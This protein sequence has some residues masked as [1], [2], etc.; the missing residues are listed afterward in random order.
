MFTTSKN[1]EID[2]NSVLNRYFILFVLLFGLGSWGEKA[3]VK[4][5]SSSVGFF[6]KE[7]YR[8]KC[9]APIMAAHSTD[10]DLRKR[11]D[12]TEFVK[13]F[14]D[15]DIYDD[16]INDHKISEDFNQACIRYGK[17]KVIKNGTLP[18]VTDST[19][20]KLVQDFREKNWTLAVLTAADLGH[21]VGDGFMPLHITANYN[22]KLTAQTG[23][24]RRYEETMIDKYIDQISFKTS[25]I[26]KIANVHSYIFRY[27]YRNYSRVSLLLQ[28]DSYAYE[29]AGGRY[30]SIYYENLWGKTHLFT[31]K[32]LEESAKTLSALIY[33]AWLEAG[34]PSIPENLCPG[35]ENQLQ[36]QNGRK[37][38]R[39]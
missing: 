1:P 4:I 12:K 36:E 22:G 5:N 33:S 6:P 21:Y 8:L 26:R 28:A 31:A 24:H 19:Y 35:S 17:E 37:R 38:N 3:H 9:W 2:M 29:K 25:G 15:I 7:I 39:I 14:I 10:A 16:F 32:L 34:K 11:T 30:N 20:R 23:I 18:W 27:L 13:H